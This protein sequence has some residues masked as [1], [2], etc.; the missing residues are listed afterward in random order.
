MEYLLDTHALIWAIF[1]PDLLSPKVTEILSDK[2]NKI[3][4]ST[5]SLWEISI[6]VTIGKLEHEKFNIPGFLTFCKQ[7]RFTVLNVT[8]KNAISYQSL[9][10]FKNHRDPFDRMLIATAV[11]RRIPL[12][13]RDTRLVQYD[14]AGLM[15]VW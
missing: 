10:F 2:R 5:V 11:A 9:P 4:V 15:H 13:S 8:P 12:I 14:G 7:L 3:F 1:E 6:K